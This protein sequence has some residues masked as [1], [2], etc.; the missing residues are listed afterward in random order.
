MMW[1]F[2]ALAALPFG[3]RGGDDAV[4]VARVASGDSAALSSLYDAH[5]RAV[6][7]LALRVVGDQ[8]D[9]EDVLQEVFTQA[10]RQASRFDVSRG[11]VAAWLLTMART[12]AI[13]RLRA[14][15]ARPD[16]ASPIGDEALLGL[17][18]PVVDPGEMLAAARDGERLR[19]AL[20]ELPFMQRIAIELAYFEG[21]TQSEIAERLE[22]PLGT[23]KTRIR[24]GLLKLR[25]S[26]SRGTSGGV[27]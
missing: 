14:R 5:S 23:V 22:Q 16:T 1:L 13:D 25:D 4:C 27:A 10:W 6:Y 12:R 8:A 9:A 19:Q 21:L 24:V 2:A 17:S 7:S 3:D 26:L 20:Q 15:R 18:A 11:S